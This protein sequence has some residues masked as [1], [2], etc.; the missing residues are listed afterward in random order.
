MP[1]P[2]GRMDKAEPPGVQSLAGKCG[3]LGTD[4]ARA[5]DRPSGARA[6]DGITD[7][8]VAAMGEM[9]SDLVGPTGGETAF[10]KRRVSLERALDAIAGHR[11][12]SLSLSDHGHF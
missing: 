11:W 8:R 10:E 9:D 2:G 1:H 5:G 7:Q 3:N 12:F 6:V 4:R